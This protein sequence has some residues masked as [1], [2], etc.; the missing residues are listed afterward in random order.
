MAF[1]ENDLTEVAGRGKRYEDDSTIR[2]VGDSVATSR[3]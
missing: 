2:E 1:A 3:E